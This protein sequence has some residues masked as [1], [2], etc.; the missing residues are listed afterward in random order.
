MR[1]QPTRA[2]LNTVTGDNV[3]TSSA[4]SCDFVVADYKDEQNLPTF[5]ITLL[6]E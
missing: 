3:S 5:I 4:V 6:S 1:K 2:A